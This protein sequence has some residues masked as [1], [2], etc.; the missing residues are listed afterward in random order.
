[1][2]YRKKRNIYLTDK[3]INNLKEKARQFGLEGKGSISQFIRL[4]I[5]HHI[6]LLKGTGLIKIE[7]QE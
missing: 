6:V 5:E 2:D 4:I 3:E 7:V 1:M